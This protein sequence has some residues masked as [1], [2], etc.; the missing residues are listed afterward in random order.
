MSA[1]HRPAPS[2][3]P[4]LG[5][6]PCVPARG[7]VALG[8]QGVGT[9]CAGEVRM[10]SPSPR[11]LSE[12]VICAA[13]PAALRGQGCHEEADILSEL[14]P[15]LLAI[16]TAQ[17]IFV[18]YE[19]ERAC[20]KIAAA[21]LEACRIWEEAPLVADQELLSR[22]A[23]QLAADVAAIARLTWTAGGEC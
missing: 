2:P 6:T 16:A 8:S 12:W 10:K 15:G 14:R 23:S 9:G 17:C 18:K 4:F 5:A 19:G 7:L 20:E 11:I 21:V 22:D 13:I 3:R 1:V